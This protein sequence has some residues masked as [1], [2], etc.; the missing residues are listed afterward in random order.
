M[1]RA[2]SLVARQKSR[3]CALVQAG[4]FFMVLV[5]PRTMGEVIQREIPYP[6]VADLWY[7]QLFY[8]PDRTNF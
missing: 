6:A 1:M 5:M 2:I 7:D 3:Q 4:L 8:L